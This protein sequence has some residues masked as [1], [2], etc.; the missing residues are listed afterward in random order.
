VLDTIRHG[1]IFE[2]R[3]NRPP[4]N[5][6]DPGLI[7]ALRRALDAAPGEGAEALVL[8]GAPGMF[9]A[10]LDVP[11]LLQL[12]RDG[13][14]AA[15]SDFYA[16][17]SAIARCPVPIA[18]AIGGHS[19]AGGAVLALFCD[20]RVMADG[21]F[22]IGFNEVRVGLPLPPVI[23]A[24][25]A[26]LV[27]AH[28]AARLGMAGLMIDPREAFR[29]GLVDEVVPMAQVEEIALHW[30]HELL[31]LPR[32]AMMETR[33]TGRRSLVELF[34]RRDDSQEIEGLVE[35]WFA[36]ETRAAMHALVER[37]AAKKR[38]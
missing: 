15:W 27:G 35:R 23:H 26:R 6:L 38:G 1:S 33:E 8:S 29:I 13:I 34:D 5:A 16:L 37:L 10:G 2:L 32:R 9:S 3:L 17:M 31:A 18:A 36:D 30:G 22:R 25:L 20:Y 28:Q 24:A 12:D 7:A 4:A 14:R 19:P 21:D 11:A